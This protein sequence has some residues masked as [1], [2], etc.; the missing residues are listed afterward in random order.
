M[1]NLK[2]LNLKIDCGSLV[3]DLKDISIINLRSSKLAIREKWI[4]ALYA[5]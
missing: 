3:K 2:D 5:S 4:F 1:S